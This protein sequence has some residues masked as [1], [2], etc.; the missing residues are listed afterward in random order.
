[1]VKRIYFETTDIEVIQMYEDYIFLKYYKIEVINDV[2]NNKIME[3]DSLHYTSEKAQQIYKSLLNPSELKIY[4]KI[5]GKYYKEA[6]SY[7]EYG[8]W[9]EYY[10]EKAI[11]TGYIV[12]IIEDHLFIN[13]TLS[14]LKCKI[15]KKI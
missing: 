1:M 12:D 9:Y 2:N 11:E 10:F 5:L 13:L 7:F 6:F 3:L 15:K 14:Y 4:L 8:M